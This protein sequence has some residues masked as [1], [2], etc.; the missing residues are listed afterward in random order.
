MVAGFGIGGIKQLQIVEKSGG[1]GGVF[2]ASIDQYDELL[3]FQ[4]SLED[5]QLSGGLGGENFEAASS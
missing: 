4:S 3:V 1:H 5:E 2:V